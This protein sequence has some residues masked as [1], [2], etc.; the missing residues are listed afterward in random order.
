[1]RPDL[2]SL[3]E[4]LEVVPVKTLSYRVRIFR[5]PGL[6]SAAVSKMAA[7]PIRTGSVGVKPNSVD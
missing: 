2:R 5:R 1:M 6:P 4:T 3:V 7:P